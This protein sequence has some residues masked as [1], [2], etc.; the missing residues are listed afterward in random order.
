[1]FYKIHMIVA[2]ET[3]ER[4]YSSAKCKFCL[5]ERRTHLPQ[6]QVGSE[7]RSPIA[8]NALVWPTHL[9]DAEVLPGR[10]SGTSVHSCLNGERTVPWRAGAEGRPTLG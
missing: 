2:M 8:L 10:W 5:K 7:M 6:K 9:C 4:N 1:M 3:S